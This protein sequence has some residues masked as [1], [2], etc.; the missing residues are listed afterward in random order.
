[1]VNVNVAFQRFEL[2]SKIS[3]MFT[4]L[5]ILILQPYKQRTRIDSFYQ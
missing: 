1:M 5:D 2:C 3:S 4:F